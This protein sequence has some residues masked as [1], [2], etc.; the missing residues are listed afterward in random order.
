[1]TAHPRLVTFGIGLAITFVVGTAIGIIEHH[2]LSYTISN[3]NGNHNGNC[4][5]FVNGTC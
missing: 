1:M 4:K 2:N 5:H 3:N